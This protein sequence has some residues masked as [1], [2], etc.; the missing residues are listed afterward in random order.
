VSELDEVTLWP[1]TVT[2]IGPVA[3]PAGMMKERLPAV[4]LEMGATIVPPPCCVS[5]T[6][7][8]NPLEIKLLPVTVIPAPSAPDAGLK[9]EI[10]GAEE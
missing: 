5:V 1:F 7:G 3:A 4:T 9:P 6:S 10:V 2:V 8:L